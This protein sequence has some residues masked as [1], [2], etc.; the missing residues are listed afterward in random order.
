MAM[1]IGTFYN[2]GERF[3]GSIETRKL[4]DLGAVIID[5]YEKSSPNSSEPDYIVRSGRYQIG[6]GWKQTTKDGQREY[7]NLIIDDP[8]MDQAIRARLVQQGGKHILLWER[9]DD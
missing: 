9:S 8:H 2:N 7:I 1:Q 3:E 4:D 6:R 5:P